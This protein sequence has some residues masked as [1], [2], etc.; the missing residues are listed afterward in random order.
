[1]RT[2]VK[3]A[4]E[5]GAARC[6]HAAADGD[7]V[8]F[9]HGRP[10]LRGVGTA[11]KLRSAWPVGGDAAPRPERGLH[12][13]V[14]PAPALALAATSNSSPLDLAAI[15]QVIDLAHKSQP[16]EATTRMSPAPL[17]P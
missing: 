3:P 16:D 14:R 5:M 17:L 13:A 6:S 12:R 8:E 2:P 11:A 15:K 10:W 1:M 7:G 4:A 9:V